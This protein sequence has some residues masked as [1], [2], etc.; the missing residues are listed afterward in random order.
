MGYRGAVADIPLVTDGSAG[1]GL[2]H[3]AATS[4]KICVLHEG[5]PVIQVSFPAHAIANLPDLIPREVRPRVAALDLE[6][7]AARHAALGCPPGE[8]FTLPGRVDTVRAW[9]E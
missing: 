8:L 9:M 3:V 7:V 5:R 2:P 4:L 1:V 6:G